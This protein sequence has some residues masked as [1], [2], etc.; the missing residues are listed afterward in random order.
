MSTPP[1]ASRPTRPLQDRAT[2]APPSPAQMKLRRRSIRTLA[3]AIALASALSMIA[4]QQSA[5]GSETEQGPETIR[6]VDQDN[7]RPQGSM[8]QVEIDIDSPAGIESEMS[9]WLCK[10]LKLMCR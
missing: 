6:V 2:V 8:A 4:T 10:R 7:Q 1:P 9:K 3:S 5:S